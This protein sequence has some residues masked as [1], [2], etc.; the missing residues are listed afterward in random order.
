MSLLGDNDTRLGIIM[1][2]DSKKK[3]KEKKS[4]D[5]TDASLKYV[6]RSAILVLVAVQRHHQKT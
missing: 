6:T 1:K 4:T 3:R 2:N 5:K